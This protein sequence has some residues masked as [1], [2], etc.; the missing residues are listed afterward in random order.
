V[1][2]IIKKRRQPAPKKQLPSK[3]KPEPEPQKM[4]LTFF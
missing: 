1:K 3:P 2:E 4:V